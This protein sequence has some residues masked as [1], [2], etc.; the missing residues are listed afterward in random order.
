MKTP[1]WLIVFAS[2]TASFSSVAASNFPTADRVEFV[3]ECMRDHTGGEF[4]LLNKCSCV[5]DR[6]AEKYKYDAFVEAQTLAKSVTIAG[7]RGAVLRDNDQAQKGARKYRDTL[8][9][10][11]RA[12]F[13]ADK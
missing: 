3:L 10:A 5:I 4:E 7:E 6:L 1:N 12:C 8:A 13:L 2:L 9:A 11:S